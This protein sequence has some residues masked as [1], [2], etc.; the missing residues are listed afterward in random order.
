M[1]QVIDAA[2]QIIKDAE[3]LR[4]KAYTCPAGVP[5]IGWGHTKTVCKFDVETG[6]TI[7]QAEAQLLFLQDIADAQRAVDLYVT[8]PLTDWQYGALVS[9]AFNIGSGNFRTSTLLKLL[10]LKEYT[11][12]SEQFARWNKGRDPGTGA[13]VVLGGLVKRRERERILFCGGF[14]HGPAH[15]ED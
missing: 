10:N 3:S 2:Q 13:T 15:N 5:T 8:V 4:L 7:T 12:A 1:R 6:R 9:L 14:D 11:A